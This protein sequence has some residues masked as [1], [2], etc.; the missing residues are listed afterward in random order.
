MRSLYRAMT[1]TAILMLDPKF[2]QALR[3]SQ[4]VERLRELALEHLRQGRDHSAVLAEFE[5]A[6]QH[7]REVGREQEKDAVMDVL[8][9]LLGWCSPHMKLPPARPSATEAGG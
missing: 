3:S 6:R 4:P 7:L 1:R 2:E 8:D 9:M 5:S